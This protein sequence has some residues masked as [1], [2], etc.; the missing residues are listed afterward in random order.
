MRAEKPM[1]LLMSNY[2]PGQPIIPIAVGGGVAFVVLTICAL[3][4]RTRQSKKRLENSVQNLWQPPEGTGAD[5]RASVRREGHPVKV[6]IQSAAF[7]RNEEAYVVDRSTGGLKVASI[8][9]LSVGSSMQVRAM[10]APEN[11][12]WVNLIVRNC[13]NTGEH[14]ELGCEFEITPPWNVLLLFG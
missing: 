2:L 13:R 7:R 3:K 6:Y 1:F 14:Y 4:F 8:K 5:R 10:N 11:M 9:P 12:P